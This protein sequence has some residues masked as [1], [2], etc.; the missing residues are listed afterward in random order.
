M[1]IAAH[2][3][4]LRA[5]ELLRDVGTKPGK[6]HVHKALFLVQASGRAVPFA[7][8]LYKYGPYSFD[9][10]AAIVSMRTYGALSA[11]PVADFGVELDLGPQAGFVRSGGKLSDQEEKALARACRFVNGKN[12]QELERLA[13]AVWIRAQENLNSPI[14]AAKR[15]VALKPHVPEALALAAHE[16]AGLF[17]TASV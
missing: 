9:I 15:L 3:W 2:I 17:L 6:T 1:D 7:F 16:E 10:E 8:R 4:V 11:R 5:V 13:T 12:V 14:E